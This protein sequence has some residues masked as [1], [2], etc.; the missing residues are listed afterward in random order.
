MN[1]P[2]AGNQYPAMFYTKTGTVSTDDEQNKNS[3]NCLLCPVGCEISGGDYGLCGARRNIA[4]K[5]YAATY[6]MVSSI[7]LD[8]IEK[9]PF[10]MFYSGKRILSLGSFGCNLGCPFCQNHEIA[11]GFNRCENPRYKEEFIS[12]EKIVEL[13]KETVPEGNI[14]IAYT[15]NEP[16]IGYEFVLDCARRVCDAGLFNILVTNG[17]INPEPLEKLLP[18]IHAMNIDLKGGDGFYAKL[19]GSLGPVKET[20]AAAHKHC[21]VEITT[22]IIPD[23]NDSSEMIESAARF[24]ASVDPE[25]PLHLTRFFP[26]YKYSQ[27]PAASP[28]LTAAAGKIAKKYL[29]NVFI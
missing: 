6:G 5:L 1:D 26:R 18:F 17:Y 21:H 23:E 22:L 15:Y 25:I 20:I 19:G 12:P 4:G 3:V 13:A 16:L 24:I 9:K 29:K 28:E 10:R 27:K 2:S 8:P 14:G 11:V 7:A